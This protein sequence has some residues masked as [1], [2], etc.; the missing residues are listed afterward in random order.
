M[1]SIWLLKV[2]S[3]TDVAQNL[4]QINNFGQLLTFNYFSKAD[5]KSFLELERKL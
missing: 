5:L 4:H 3:T 1:F 2:H